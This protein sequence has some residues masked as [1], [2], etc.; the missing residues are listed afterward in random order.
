MAERTLTPVTS[1]T[2]ATAV[3]VRVALPFALERTRR[4]A[5]PVAA[6]G[7]P[8]H[9]TLLFPFLATSA[10]DRAVRGRLAAIAATVAPFDVR[11]G[12]VARFPDA[13]YLAPEPA[14]PFHDL[15]AAIV[16]TWPEHP[17][18]AGRYDEVIPHLT[19]AEGG[20]ATAEVVRLAE[21]SLPFVRSVAAIEVIDRDSTARWH[22]RWRIALGGRD[23]KP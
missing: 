2:T 10:L 4:M 23:L 8:A 16:A 13:I 6:V 12:R 11:F 18:Y 9:V 3:I 17:A 21:R 20:G 14:T 5:S 15:I 19:I 1:E 7:V 22:R